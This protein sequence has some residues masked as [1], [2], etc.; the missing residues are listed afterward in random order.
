MKHSW[1]RGV[2]AAAVLTALLTVSAGAASPCTAVVDA[3]GL[4]LRGKANTGSPILTMAYRG[5]KVDVLEDAGNGWYKVTYRGTTGYM[6][7]EYLKL[8]GTLPAAAQPEKAAEPEK[9][10][11]SEQAAQPEQTAEIAEQETPAAAAPDLGRGKVD[12]QSYDV[13]NLRS[14]PSTEYKKVGSV[15][16]G[17]VLTLL[18]EQ[19]G[20]YK[21]TYNGKE[22]YV[23]GDYIKRITQEES[24]AADQTQDQSEFGTAIV[25]LAKKYIG[26]PYVW[27][28]NGPSGFDCSGFTCYLYRQMGVTI[29]RGGTG[30][31]NAGTPVSRENVQPG[32]LVFISDPVYTNGYPISHVGM[33]IGNGQF[34]HASSNRNEG[35]TISNIF[36]GRYGTYYAGARRF[37]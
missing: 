29:P 11:E 10:T 15:P 6:S 18:E 7:G 36:T 3:D 20:W 17:A 4:R 23:C 8:E 33:Y 2:F 35:V 14:G 1:L 32:D 37:V 19:D 26:T 21:V 34:I 24:V 22:G 31:Y 28:G 16:G 25:A 30:Q 9:T 12:L 27:G 5:D 13:L